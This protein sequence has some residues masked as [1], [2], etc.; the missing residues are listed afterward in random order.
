MDTKHVRLYLEPHSLCFIKYSYFVLK[1]LTNLCFLFSTRW[2]KCWNSQIHHTLD[3]ASPVTFSR[4]T[5]ESIMDI[6][7]WPTL[8]LSLPTVPNS[9]IG[10]Y[11]SLSWSIPRI[12]ASSRKVDLFG[13]HLVLSY[14][15]NVDR[16]STRYNNELTSY[17]FCVF[18][19]DY[20]LSWF[21][22][23]FKYICHLKTTLLVCPLC[24]TPNLGAHMSTGMGNLSLD[25]REVGW[26]YADIIAA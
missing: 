5:L 9:T 26:K 17:L 18:C 16:M 2:V 4:I 7:P 25:N 8:L 11:L 15:K 3:S 19:F 24:T 12:I 20:L 6:L 10:N 1:H 13:T 14:I 23:Y 22:F 21:R